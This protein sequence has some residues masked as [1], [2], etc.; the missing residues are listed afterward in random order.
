MKYKLCDKCKDSPTV[1]GVRQF[2]LAYALRYSLGRQTGSFSDVR[3]SITQN[4]DKFQK[5]EIEIF[6]KELKESLI[7]YPNMFYKNE[8]E[9]FIEYLEIKKEF[10]EGE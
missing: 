9:Y 4:I 3:S 8:I 2:I 1:K 6:I 10:K 5:W 7:D